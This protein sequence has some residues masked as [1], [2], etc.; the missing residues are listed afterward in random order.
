MDRM[1]KNGQVVGHMDFGAIKLE[2]WGLLYPVGC[3]YSGK[4]DSQR[5]KVKKDYFT[6]LKQWPRNKYMEIVLSLIPCF[7]GGCRPIIGIDEEHLSGFYKGYLLTTVVIDDYN[8]IFPFAHG[9]VDVESLKNQGYV[10]RNL[11]LLF[12]QHGVEKDDWCFISDGVKGVEAY[13]HEVFPKVT[14]RICCQHLYSKCKNVKESG[15]TF[16]DLFWVAANAYNHY[17]YNKAIDKIIKLDPAAFDYLEKSHNTIAKPYRDLPLITLLEA[18]TLPF[19][20]C[21]SNRTWCMKRIGMR[22]DKVIDIDPND[23]KNYAAKNLER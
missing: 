12:H 3:G 11:R 5:V 7:Q 23:V 15:T 1:Y 8:E 14:R 13:L 20:L 18:L 2:T 21:H 16:H 6:R 4:A 9:V 10:I 19:Q 22:F 17:V